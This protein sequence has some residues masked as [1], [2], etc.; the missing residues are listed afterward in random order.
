M[1]RR[2]PAARISTIWSAS[3]RS[4]SGGRHEPRQRGVRRRRRGRGD[5]AGVDHRRDLEARLRQ[6]RGNRR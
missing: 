3:W 6:G 1:R 4:A 2:C 5:R